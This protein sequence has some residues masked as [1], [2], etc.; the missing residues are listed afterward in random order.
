MKTRLAA[1]AEE[2]ARPWGGG[3]DCALC[4]LRHSELPMRRALLQVSEG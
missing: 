2:R 4:D 3:S 1:L